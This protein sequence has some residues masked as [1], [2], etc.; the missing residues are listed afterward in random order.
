MVSVN[1]STNQSSQSNNQ[2]NR[3]FQG[4]MI[5]VTILLVVIAIITGSLMFWVSSLNKE[6][7]DS[8]AMYKAK[9]AQLRA[10]PENNDIA[11]FQERILA[12]E[13]LIA[14]PDSSLLALQEVEK[15]IVSGLYLNSYVFDAENKAIEL[16]CIVDNFETVA[17]QIVGFKSSAYFSEVSAK[18]VSLDSD[19][20]S[21]FLIDI[22]IN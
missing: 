12:A 17:K 3:I 16:E 8:E 1:L 21:I 19:G 10:F 7:V 18:S 22:K 4:G 13:D 6:I 9:E 11:D 2:K 20:K 5:A 14:Q 15:N